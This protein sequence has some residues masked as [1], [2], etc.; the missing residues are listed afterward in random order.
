MPNRSAPPPSARPP[1]RRR[2]AD[3][4][5]DRRG[6]VAIVLGM[7]AVPLVGLV[8]L[9]IDYSFAIRSQSLLNSA[10]D[11]AA[12]AAT[13][14]AANAFQ[15]NQTVAASVSAGQ[16]AGLRAFNAQLANLPN[17]SMS[18]T[19]SCNAVLSTV[20]VTVAQNPAGSATFVTNI[21]YSASYQTWFGGL[22]AVPT[23]PI[24]GGSTATIALKAYEDFNILMDNSGSMQIASTPADMATLGPLTLKADQSACKADGGVRGP[25][26]MCGMAQGTNCAF[27]CHW[28]SSG[29]DFYQVAQSNGVPTRW[30]TEQSAV[31]QVITTMSTQNTISQYRVAVYTFNNALTKVYPTNSSTPSTDLLDGA[32]A[33][34]NISPL[35][36]GTGSNEPDTNF[37]AAMTSLAPLLPPAGDGSSGSP[38]E[39]LFIITDGI[40]DYNQSGC[41]NPSGRCQQPITP[42]ECAAIK[43]AGVQILVL[44]VQYVPLDTSYGGVNYNNGWYDTYIQKYVDPAPYTG[45]TDPNSA[46]Q[47]NLTAC[48]SSPSFFF[49]AS[50]SSQISTQLNAMLTAA[51]NTGVRFT[52]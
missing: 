33:A 36:V 34:Q 19:I 31:Q 50:D 49:Y 42:S 15:N 38:K 44:Y 48:A 24:S 10:A 13:D 2:W 32:T 26:S 18:A 16:A 28:L 51:E 29:T 39:F 8:G 3:L 9:A 25:P 11:S 7:L 21:L 27:G 23:F 4:L 35:V 40:E 6:V 30:N 47:T 46:V 52:Q 45:T 37:G 22:F 1:V 17:V 14:A 5:R 41:N 43:A 12:I 20:C